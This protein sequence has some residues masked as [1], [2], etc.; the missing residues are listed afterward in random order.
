VR[1]SVSTLGLDMKTPD[2]LTTK[3]TSS[4][5]LVKATR[6]TGIW[7]FVHRRPWN[8]ESTND[9]AV[10]IDPVAVAAAASENLSKAG[11]PGIS[12]M[13]ADFQMSLVDKPIGFVE[14]E[15]ENWYNAHRPAVADE[16]GRRLTTYNID[17]LSATA[18][19]AAKEA[20]DCYIDERYLSVV[21]VLMP[22]FE[23]FGRSVYT[24]TSAPPTQRQAID[25][26]KDVID[27]LPVSGTDAIESFSLHHFI[28]DKLFARCFSVAEAQALGTFPNRHAELHGLATYGNFKGATTLL[29]VMGLLLQ[30]MDRFLVL[31]NPCMPAPDVEA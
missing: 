22:E 29:C 16:L 18:R 30:L 6:G 11:W 27:S 3:K 14:K 17:A 8:L 31:R 2:S 23:T 19:T 15:V 1:R 28:E 10:L 9:E 7:P 12:L 24:G 5:R 13:S 25:S 4:P 20:I 21:R 26:L